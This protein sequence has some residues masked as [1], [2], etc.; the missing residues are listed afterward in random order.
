MDATLNEIIENQAPME[1]DL[2]SICSTLSSLSID[3]PVEEQ[4]PMFQRW[5]N[6]QTGSN[7]YAGMP[8][9]GQPFVDCIVCGD[10][11]ASPGNCHSWCG[12]H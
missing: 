9:P 6:D 3:E 12:S 2:E 8:A 1:A 11:V 7:Y 10:P 5:S 4:I